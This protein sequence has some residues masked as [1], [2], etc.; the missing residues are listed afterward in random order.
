MRC[1]TQA[2]ASDEALIASM[3]SK[4]IEMPRQP[5]TSSERWLVEAFCS[6]DSQLGKMG[7]SFGHQVLRLTKAVN[8]MS[9]SGQDLGLTVIKGSDNPFLWGSLPCTP[10]CHWQRL[11]LARGTQKTINKITQARQESIQAL[12]VFDKLGQA[13]AEAEGAMAFEWPTGI[14]G[15]QLPELQHIIEKFQLEKVHFHGCMFG[16]S[17]PNGSLMKKAWTVATNCPE[18]KKALEVHKCDGNHPHFMIQGDLTELSGFYPP[19][20][21]R[22]IHQALQQW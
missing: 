7:Q 17:A 8:L 19:E 11:N 20:M 16:L 10:W 9:A 21:A 22:T 18:L 15:W 12:A 4:N 6:E 14:E 1:V 5:S 3:R 2:R 13:V